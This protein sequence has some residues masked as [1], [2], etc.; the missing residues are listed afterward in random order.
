[1]YKYFV[2][3]IS[4]FCCTCVRKSAQK[5]DNRK[6]YQLY[7]SLIEPVYLPGCLIQ[8]VYLP[9]REFDRT[10]LFTKDRERV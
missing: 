3:A 10:S 4:A 2:I 5:V 1:M 6:K 8:P 7:G 9:E